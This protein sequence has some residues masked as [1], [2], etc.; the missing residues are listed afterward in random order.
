MPKVT[1]GV[2]GWRLHWLLL[3]LSSSSLL[4]F[5]VVS[6]SQ[7]PGEGTGLARSGFQR[8]GRVSR[9]SL[10]SPALLPHRTRR[11]LAHPGPG[12][13]RA[14]GAARTPAVGAVGAAGGWSCCWRRAGC[15]PGPRGRRSGGPAAAAAAPSRRG[16]KP[17]PPAVA[18]PG[19]APSS[20]ARCGAGGARA[21]ARCPHH[22][23]TL[24][25][26]SPGPRRR[27]ALP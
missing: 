11:A 16:E 24:E 26:S 19:P 6:I 17:A 23:V 1:H 18:S 20:P 9:I 10:P 7:V 27:G 15:A 13:R 12:P 2:R 21:S 5:V 25:G 22:A 14:P 4:E 3:G 8:S